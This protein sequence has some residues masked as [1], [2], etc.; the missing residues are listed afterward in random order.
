M[1]KNICTIQDVRQE[2]KKLNGA[3]YYK[4]APL[5]LKL[6]TG[7]SPPEIADELLTQCRM[8]FSDLMKLQLFLGSGKNS[9]SYQY[10]IYKIFNDILPEDDFENRQILNFIHLPTDKTLQR[11]EQEWNRLDIFI[12]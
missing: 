3:K 5:I 2:L 9:M 7:I 12:C 4:H 1:S 10:I 11:L 8:L 6:I